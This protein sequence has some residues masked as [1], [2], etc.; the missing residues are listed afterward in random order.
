MMNTVK[1]ADGTTLA[2]DIYGDGPPLIFITG[3][4]CF[5]NFG[6]VVQDAKGFAKEFTVYNYDRRGRG[7]STD[8]QPYAIAREIEDIEAM[9]DAAGGKA[10]LYGHSSGAV[11]ALEAAL[12]LPDKIDKVLLYDPPYVHDETEKATYGKLSKQVHSLLDVGKNGPAMRTFLKGIG[13]PTFFVYLM[14]IMPGWKSMR[15]LAPTLAY[16]IELTRDLPPVDRAA[17]V[18]VPMQ[19][20]VGEKSPESVKSSAKQLADA[21]PDVTLIE[22]AGQDHMVS[23]KALLP[24]LTKFLKTST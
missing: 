8:T 1:S 24:L 17:Q 2:Y 20:V 6:P 10:N 12:R 13:M 9:I 18:T 21:M 15:N 22:L 3:A 7:D 19:I 4:S 16:D 23:A 11:L 14:P 5:R